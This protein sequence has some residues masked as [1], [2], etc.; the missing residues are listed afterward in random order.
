MDLLS[1]D[2]RPGP[3]TPVTT[4]P[5][6]SLFAV[7]PQMVALI[8]ENICLPGS[9]RLLIDFN[10]G[11]CS[12]PTAVESIPSTYLQEWQS[13]PTDITKRILDRSETGGV[14]FNDSPWLASIRQDINTDADRATYNW[15]D[16]GN[17]NLFP[18]NVNGSLHVNLVQTNDPLGYCP[19]GNNLI[20]SQLETGERVVWND[21]AEN[22][23]T[24]STQIISANVHATTASIG[25]YMTLNRYAGGELEFVTAIPVTAAG[26]IGP[27]TVNVTLMDDYWWTM[28]GFEDAVVQGG[29]KVTQSWNCETW[30]HITTEKFFDNYQR[31]GRGR[32]RMLAHDMLIKCGAAEFYDIGY[33]TVARLQ[34]DTDW[35]SML[36]TSQTSS[37]FKKVSSYGNR[38]LTYSD[39]LA[40]GI[41]FFMLPSTKDWDTPR[42]VCEVDPVSANIFDLSYRREK[43]F[44]APMI[45]CARSQNPEG[46]TQLTGCTVLVEENQSFAYTTSNPENTEITPAHTLETIVALDSLRYQKTARAVDQ[47]SAT[48]LSEREKNDNAFHLKSI[49][50]GIGNWLNGSKKLRSMGMQYATNFLTPY[51]GS[52]L[53]SVAG[54]ALGAAYDGTAGVLAGV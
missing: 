40:A 38:K 1:P 47:V 34:A 8:C 44:F 50:Q 4:F 20:A 27:F 53:A 18:E 41:H 52:G 30:A 33:I 51:V 13:P 7:R 23:T 17:T 36:S 46:V 25:A 19:H 54:D 6:Q 21:A 45:W 29:W 5:L 28:S 12:D 39:R 26:P 9:A 37:L 3:D 10:T 31:Y 35:W 48:S 2:F 42:T 43:N 49:L 24:P 16:N 32:V 15:T 14:I 22:N 11:G